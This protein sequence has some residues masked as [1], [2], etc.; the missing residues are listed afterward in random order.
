MQMAERPLGGK[1]RMTQ[2]N[3]GIKSYGTKEKNL[4]QCKKRQE[5]NPDG[6]K[7]PGAL[8]NVYSK[9]KHSHLP[10]DLIR[11]HKVIL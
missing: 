10:M 6:I 1:V 3:M 11:T 5:H 9:T 7:A 4:K 8:S 2:N